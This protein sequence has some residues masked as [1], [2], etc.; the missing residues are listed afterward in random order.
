MKYMGFISFLLISSHLYPMCLSNAGRYLSDA[1]KKRID[2]EVRFGPYKTSENVPFDSVL[3][4]DHAEVWGIDEDGIT[5][6]YKVVSGTLTVTGIAASSKIEEEGM[7]SD[8]A[9]GLLKQSKNKAVSIVVKHL[10]E[11]DTLTRGMS[12]RVIS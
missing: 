10:Y 7:L 6:T 12:F 5:Y 2:L 9:K 3:V 8:R 4:Y 1:A 11:G